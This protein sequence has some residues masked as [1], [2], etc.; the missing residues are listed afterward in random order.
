M[1]KQLYADILIVNALKEEQFL[2]DLVYLEAL[3]EKFAGNATVEEISLADTNFFGGQVLIKFPTGQELCIAWI[4]LGDGKKNDGNSMGNIFAYDACA[5]L[6]ERFCPRFILL[7]GVAGG[8]R[9]KFNRGDVGFGLETG[10]TSYCKIDST[11]SIADKIKDNNTL[12]DQEQKNLLES[13]KKLEIDAD[14]EFLNYT[15]RHIPR[16][17]S[18]EEFCATARG[19][20]NQP[21]WKKLAKNWFSPQNISA[22]LE[23]KTEFGLDCDTQS[24]FERDAPI[25]RGGIVA[26]GE[27]IIASMSLQKKIQ[28]QLNVVNPRIK[29]YETANMFEMESFGVGYFC[30]ENRIGYG[31]IKGIC[32]FAGEGKNDEYRLCAISSAS[33]FAFDII[34][35]E[36]FYNPILQ[37]KGRHVESGKTACIW[38]HDNVI[39]KRCIDTW[40]LTAAN[41]LNS[42]RPCT[43]SGL[44]KMRESNELRGARLFQQTESAEY[45]RCV[46]NF[47]DTKIDITGGKE[48]NS[49]LFLFPYS[50]HDLFNF[51]RNAGT[52][53]EAEINKVLKLEQYI[54]GRVDSNPNAA[55]NII[56]YAIELGQNAYYN[57]LHFGATN[58]KCADWISEG[59]EFEDIAKKIC[60]VIF[61]REEDREYLFDDPR[62]LMHVF[63]CGLCVPTLIAS[64]A[65]LKNY[66]ADEATYFNF[67]S[68]HCAS[69]A[70]VS[71]NMTL[72]LKYSDRSKLLALIGQCDDVPHPRFEVKAFELSDKI[73][74]WIQENGKDNTF[75]IFP[76]LNI[77]F[78][79]K[80]N[81]KTH[82]SLVPNFSNYT[83]DQKTNIA[84]YFEGLFKREDS[85]DETETFQ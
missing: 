83:E 44:I 57:H 70:R 2:L 48:K 32:D 66:G 42:H 62:F 24:N 39:H 27:A 60:R 43:D 61:I 85:P 67:R 52:L 54:P 74:D 56:N 51:L 59:M 35:N 45:S 12:S 6:A 68:A 22:F 72:C 34:T 71:K 63:M 53:N 55:K 80:I 8:S 23:K 79:H 7:L 15:I 36:A 25:A 19:I 18:S 49:L 50:V 38:Q 41:L 1:I 64:K 20:C 31:M 82:Q 81:W 47:I 5:E 30:T 73:E 3:R 26:S 75:K 46:K 76:L 13:L 37:E 33:A 11:P 29:T 10:Y 9:T 4:T 28:S 40:S 16:V 65:T 77:L 21:Q 78:L 84:S 14:A 69:Q 58:K 17:P